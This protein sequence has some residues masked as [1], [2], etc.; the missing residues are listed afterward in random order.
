MYS[1]NQRTLPIFEKVQTKELKRKIWKNANADYFYCSTNSEFVSY[2][3][4]KTWPDFIT[5]K[6]ERNLISFVSFRKFLDLYF[7]AQVYP[8]V[9][10]FFQ[11]SILKWN[12]NEDMANSS[13]DVFL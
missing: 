9:M 11:F 7:I 4:K 8:M 13:Q 3:V 2:S 6:N 10:F 5:C 12:N 1:T